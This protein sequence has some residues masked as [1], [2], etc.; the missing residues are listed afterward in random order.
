M[1][2]MAACMV[3]SCNLLSKNP[4]GKLMPHFPLHRAAPAFDGI[5]VAVSVPV[6]PVQRGCG[7]I[8]GRVSFNHIFYSKKE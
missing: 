6:S 2:S 1:K 3:T 5:L 8:N 4:P 7:Q